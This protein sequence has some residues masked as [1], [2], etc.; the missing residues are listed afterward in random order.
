[1]GWAILRDNFFSPIDAYSS[2]VESNKRL[3]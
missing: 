1:M 3:N 2:A